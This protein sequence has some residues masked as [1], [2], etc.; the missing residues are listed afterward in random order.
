[1]QIIRVFFN[2]IFITLW[3]GV[4]NATTYYVDSGAGNDAN[5]GKSE[6]A[7]WRSIAKVNGAAF[8]PG[9]SILFKRGSLWREQLA[10]PASGS[11]AAPITF[12]AYGSSTTPPVISGA[13]PVTGWTQQSGAVWRAPCAVSPATVAFNGVVGNQK[14]ALAS[15][16]AGKD[17][18]WSAGTLYACSTANPATAFG[19]GGVEAGARD[20]C[21]YSTG[22][23]WVHYQGLSLKYGN[24]SC[25][26][27][28]NKD[29]NLTMTDVGSFGAG[30]EGGFILNSSANPTLTRCHS[31]WCRGVSN[32]DGYVF[33]TPCSNV[34][35]RDCTASYNHRRGAQFDTGI[36][37][38]IKILG[39]EF[40]HQYSINQSDG[41][42]I[43]A[44]DHI[45]VEGVWSHDN[46]INND[47]ADGLQISG[48]S[49]NPVI[50]YCR[51]EHNFNGGIVLE[52]DG[53]TIEGNISSFNRHG[54]AI[55][56]NATRPKYIYN[57]TFFNNE[58]GVFFYE[59]T[60]VAPVY[61]KNNILYGASDIRRAAYLA[62]GLADSSIFM[63]NNGFWGDTDTFMIQWKGTLY[64]RSQFS[65][66]VSDTKKNLASIC[67]NP[68]FVGANGSDLRLRPG[69]P[70]IGKGTPLA[71]PRDFAGTPIPAT[72]PDIGAYQSILG[73]S[74]RNGVPN[75][76]VYH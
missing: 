13:N 9:D 3:A 73:K 62:S 57:N 14:D 6:S 52:T 15:L 56:G 49:V 55:C 31:D 74:I 12:G 50:R 69:S 59:I 24:R 28:D 66:F 11:S 23:S 1:M 47:S 76:G 70:L 37:G 22:K 72:Q 8:Q 42:A 18:Y 53:A 43:D 75:W 67:A 7:S 40:H 51:L 29:D 46:G 63:D 20:Y 65:R 38:F 34:T 45:L 48:N 10:V 16:A 33:K 17:W 41:L 26:R 4:A 54:V 44:N 2:I 5:S 19:S 35:L 60:P 39:G 71:L 21:I 27:A 61:V 30:A 25:F 58:F 64:S 36:G 32:G 68:L